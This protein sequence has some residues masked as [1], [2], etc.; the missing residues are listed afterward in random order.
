MG[1]YVRTY[2]CLPHSWH[3]PSGWGDHCSI[4]VLQH[5]KTQW[6]ATQWEEGTSISV[7]W[8]QR[9]YDSTHACST[10]GAGILYVYMCVYMHTYSTYVSMCNASNAWVMIRRGEGGDVRCTVIHLWVEVVV[11]CD[12][13]HFV[14]HWF[15]SLLMAWFYLSYSLNFT[16]NF[17]LYASLSLLC[18][19]KYHAFD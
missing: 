7:L 6:G 16:C 12:M 17:S 18:A 14:K 19:T 15:S 4:K 2:V 10:H 9:R 11:G 1:T 13:R 5:P 3:W 8:G